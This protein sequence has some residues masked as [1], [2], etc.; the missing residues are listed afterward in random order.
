MVAVNK[1][2]HLAE[3]AQNLGLKISEKGS[4]FFGLCQGYPLQLNLEM[5]G[6]IMVIKAIWVMNKEMQSAQL[7]DR[8]KESEAL[9]TAG[10]KASHFKFANGYLVHVFAPNW[11]GGYDAPEITTKLT[12]FGEFLK[13]NFPAPKGPCFHCREAESGELL[14]MK[15]VVTQ[16]CKSCENSLRAADEKLKADYEA[17]PVLW[18]RAIPAALVSLVVGSLIW[19]L[20]IRLTG[21]MYFMLSVVIGL[22]IAFSVKKAAGKS[23]LGVQILAGVATLVSLVMGIVAYIGMFVQGEAAAHGQSVNWTVFATAIPDMLIKS[24]SDTAFTTFAGLVGAFYAA[25]I[26]GKPKLGFWVERVASAP[27]DKPGLRAS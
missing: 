12:K 4:A 10:L 14:L 7:L 2:K 27:S 15:D 21:S 26:A 3:I 11:K 5:Q 24:G 18:G 17:K 25:V 22:G 16:V 9:K 13:T 8:L 1:N 19:G 23:N 6:K 20:V